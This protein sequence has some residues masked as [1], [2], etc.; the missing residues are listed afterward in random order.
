MPLSVAIVAGTGSLGLGLALR[1]AQAGEKVLLGSRTLDKA[2]S[3]ADQVRRVVPACDVE[4]LLYADAVQ[5]APVVVLALPLAARIPT[6]KLLKDYW[7]TN[8]ILVETA[9]PLERAVG[10]RLSHILPLWE[11]SAAE[12]SARY[13]PDTVRVTAALHSVS[14]KSLQN[15]EQPLKSDVLV[16]GNDRE[17]RRITA[18]LIGKIP[19][20]RTIDAGP[21]ENARYAEHLAALLIALNLRHE[22]DSS[23]I[24][25]TGLPGLEDDA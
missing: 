13:V 5:Q 16:V 19:G 21:L 2:R 17:A 11:G 6:L 24:R 18:D 3:A 23:G 9:V 22:V 25:F 12:Q 14:A 1:W 4:A 10:G 20:A 7:Q 15:L 8:A